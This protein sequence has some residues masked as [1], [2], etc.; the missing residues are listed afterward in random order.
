MEGTLA[1]RLRRMRAVVND[2]L[3]AGIDGLIA[4]IERQPVSVAVLSHVATFLSD[5]KR[6]QF[7]RL[8]AHPAVAAKIIV[9]DKT[10]WQYEKESGVG[11]KRGDR[12]LARIAAER[13]DL[14]LE[15]QFLVPLIPSEILKKRKPD[16][17][18]EF[19]QLIREKKVKV[20]TRPYD[21][22]LDLSTGTRQRDNR[23]AAWGNAEV[24]LRLHKKA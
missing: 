23:I 8:F 3:H 13:P 5:Q 17:G 15:K 19:A 4:T 7:F 12:E 21:Y 6:D 11:E 18:E 10:L 16:G 1:D 24:I 14:T 9:A 22:S 2:S 20:E